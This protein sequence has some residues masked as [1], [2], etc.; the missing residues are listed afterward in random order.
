MVYASHEATALAEAHTRTERTVERLGARV[1]RPAI[2]Q[3]H[4]DIG[5][6]PW[7]FAS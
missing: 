3:Q 7:Y 6:Q 5:E 4:V 2:A 1:D